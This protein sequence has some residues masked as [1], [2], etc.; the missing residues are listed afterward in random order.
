MRLR[1]RPAPGGGLRSAADRVVTERDDCKAFSAGLQLACDSL[2]DEKEKLKAEN[3]ELSD[4]TAEFYGTD[5]EM[6]VTIARLLNE[7][8]KLKK[9]AKAAEELMCED[10]YHVPYEKWDAVELALQELS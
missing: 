8:A 6:A 5:V 9:V 10:A 7:N 2:R 4:M 3:K 1:P